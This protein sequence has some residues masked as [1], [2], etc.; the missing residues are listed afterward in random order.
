M[1]ATNSVV[2]VKKIISFGL[3][4]ANILRRLTNGNC[5]AALRRLG[6]RKTAVGL[7]PFVRLLVLL[8][9]PL[10]ATAKRQLPRTLCDMPADDNIPLI[11]QRNRR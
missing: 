7:S 8:R 2:A 11:C 10:F 1:I 3:T 6:F 4:V 9:K 5:F